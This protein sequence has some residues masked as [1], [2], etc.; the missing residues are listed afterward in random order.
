MESLGLFLLLLLLLFFH[1]DLFIE[2]EAAWHSSVETVSSLE[3]RFAARTHA[4]RPTF[5]CLL[6]ECVYDRRHAQDGRNRN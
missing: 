2:L 6:R 5:V 1:V 4:L 3:L